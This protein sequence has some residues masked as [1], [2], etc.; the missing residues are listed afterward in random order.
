[1][2]SEQKE[3]CVFTGS[4]RLPREEVRS[5][6]WGRETGKLGGEGCLNSAIKIGELV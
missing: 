6:H 1:M 3:P 4:G 2:T 5:L